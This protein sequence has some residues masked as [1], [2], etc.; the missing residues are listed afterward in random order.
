[1]PQA[2]T[3]FRT[4]EWPTWLDFGWLLLLAAYVL[5]G[6]QTVP[7]HGDEAT[8]LYMGRDLPVLL[9]GDGQ[10]LSFTPAPKDGAA[11]ELR[12]INGSLTTWLYGSAGVALGYQP[13][14]WT[15]QWDWG[16]GDGANLQMGA[17]PPAD[18]LLASRALSAIT[19]SAGLI[20]LYAIGRLVNGRALGLIA[21]TLLAVHPVILMSSRRAMFEGPMVATSLFVILAGLGFL[22]K[23]GWVSSAL[24]GLT[25]GLAIAA[26][27]TNLIVVLAVFFG[28]LFAM[29]SGHFQQDRWLRRGQIV[30]ALLFGGLVFLALNPGWWGQNVP[31]T[32]S[33]VVQDRDALLKTQVELYGGYESLAD[34]AAG[35]FSDS[36][37]PAP[38][39][40][41]VVQHAG[42][43]AETSA[44]LSG[45][46][47]G[48]G[49]TGFPFD[50]LV[51]MA[52]LTGWVLL[53][54][55]RQVSRADKAILLAW[56]TL[57]PLIILITNP[58][59]WQR[60][61]L[62]NYPIV[63]L[64]VAFA[65]VTGLRWIHSRLGSPAPETTYA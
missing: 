56:A 49:I 1:M 52:T 37:A 43:E 21:A 16:Q 47:A 45:P 60:Y 50:I 11:Q 51:G 58:L 22:R 32:A 64:G 6:I 30:A 12:L 39:F 25:V 10:S 3:R 62:P 14:M 4:P 65:A 46:F 33:I 42:I 63:V 28:L 27:H 29:A 31:E 53:A 59:P 9:A 23:P 20:A 41:E 24:F 19:L 34:R 40:F 17:M 13:G 57:V 61:Y 2:P 8:I 54:R 44:Y 26:K 48:I 55:S 36:L 15:N 7:F 5:A 35:L 38:D 18:H